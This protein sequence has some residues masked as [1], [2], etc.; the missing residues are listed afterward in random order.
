MTQIGNAGQTN[1]TF[2]ANGGTV[3][4]DVKADGS[5][6][7]ALTVDGNVTLGVGATTLQVAI[8]GA[9][10]PRGK[11]VKV[12]DVAGGTSAAGAFALS[13]PID[14]G[15]FRFPTSVLERNAADEDWYLN[16]A[17]DAA[18]FSPTSTMASALPH[19][20][21][22]AARPLTFRE[23]TLGRVWFGD[24]APLGAGLTAGA[25]GAVREKEGRLLLAALAGDVLSAADAGEALTAA[26]RAGDWTVGRT[27]AWMTAGG[28]DGRYTPVSGDDAMSRLNVRQGWVQAGVDFLFHESADG[29][30]LFGGPIFQYTRSE[31]KARGAT[32][33]DTLSLDVISLGLGVSWLGQNGFYVDGQGS[34]IH[35]G[36]TLDAEAEDNTIED[37]GGL[38][39]AVSAE[40]GQRLALA[41]S[42]TATPQAQLVYSYVPIDE[43]TDSFGVETRS[44]AAESLRLRGGLEVERHIALDGAEDGKRDAIVYGLVNVSHEFKSKTEAEVAGT[45][46]ASELD[47][48]A[49]E[50]GVGGAYNWGGR[51]SV[52]GQVTAGTGFEDFGRDRTVEG[53]VGFMVKF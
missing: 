47:P 38:G 12:V 7:D 15:A 28:M 45:R 40:V 49:A 18:L 32:G 25:A 13:G 31:S 39:Y 23:R 27:G 16:L 44:I 3:G 42:W 14:L 6:A 11:T 26:N 43:F 50:V 37:V 20:L 48:W 4:I 8:V 51:F 10:D 34:A 17:A 30:R 19:A 36:G 24:R 22:T 21:V 35:Y 29:D 9:G 2:V 41:S 53:Q 33:A 46:I 52:H 5:A 1:G